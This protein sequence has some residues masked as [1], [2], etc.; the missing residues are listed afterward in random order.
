METFL[1]LVSNKNKNN[2]RIIVII[3]TFLWAYFNRQDYYLFNFHISGKETDTRK[4][5]SLNND[6]FLTCT[7]ENKILKAHVKTDSK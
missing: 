5:F 7:G 2:Q 3:I 4:L 1:R 6:L